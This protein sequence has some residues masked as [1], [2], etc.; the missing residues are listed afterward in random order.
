MMTYES[1]VRL[2]DKARGDGE[3]ALARVRGQQAQLENFLEELN[4]LKEEVENY[5]N[6]NR[7]VEFEEVMNT[8]LG[9]EREVE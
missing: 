9:L 6:D 5:K 4:A 3:L 7:V 2:V 8:L 1:L